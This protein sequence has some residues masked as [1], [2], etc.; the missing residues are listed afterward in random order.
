[1]LPYRLNIVLPIFALALFYAPNAF[2][3]LDPATG[4]IILQS[5][6]AGVAIGL[7]MVK[8]YW[9]KCKEFFRKLLGK[10]PANHGK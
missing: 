2:A 7:G 1:M 5:I 9:H 10:E 8:L 6:I 4:S 3:Y